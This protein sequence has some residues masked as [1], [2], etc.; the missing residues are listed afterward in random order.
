MRDQGRMT[1]YFKG[2]EVKIIEAKIIAAQQLL[3]IASDCILPLP[4][5]LG[6]INVS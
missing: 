3:A 1:D 5:G 2:A 4:I 6:P